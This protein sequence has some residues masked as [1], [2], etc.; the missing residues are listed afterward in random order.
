MNSFLVPL[1]LETVIK[2]QNQ[3]IINE[4][5]SLPRKLLCLLVKNSTESDFFYLRS[6]SE[7][8]AVRKISLFSQVETEYPIGIFLKIYFVS[9]S[10]IQFLL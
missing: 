5:R 3:R 6:V 4:G 7:T 1:L 2:I 10:S 9:C 8:F